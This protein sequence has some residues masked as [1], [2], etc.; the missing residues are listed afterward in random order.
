M[1]RLPALPAVRSL[2]VAAV[3]AGVLLTS[4]GN[5]GPT[6]AGGK[7]AIASSAD[8]PLGNPSVDLL[9]SRDFAGCCDPRSEF[10]FLFVGGSTAGPRDLFRARPDLL[11]PEAESESPPRKLHSLYCVWLI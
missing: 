1:R 7:A 9:R 10:A 4:V 8:H 5:E 11:A 2:L 6:V 3:C